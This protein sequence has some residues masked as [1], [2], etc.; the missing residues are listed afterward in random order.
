MAVEG[1]A[2]LEPGGLCR[3]HIERR[4]K[5][6][7]VAG[8]REKRWRD[9]YTRALRHPNAADSEDAELVQQ[10]LGEGDVVGI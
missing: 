8:R 10:A 9:A 3:D 5:L 1:S 6:Q 4:L 7:D 2:L